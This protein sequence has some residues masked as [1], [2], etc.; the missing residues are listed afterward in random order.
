T[1][2]FNIVDPVYK[3][4]IMDAWNRLGLDDVGKWDE[5]SVELLRTSII[6]DHGIMA[7][8]IVS[9]FYGTAKTGMFSKKEISGIIQELIDFIPEDALKSNKFQKINIRI[10]NI[11]NNILGQYD[12]GVLKISNNLITDR[13]KLKE[14]VYHELMHWLH[15]DTMNQRGENFKK[16]ISDIFSKR[17]AG[18]PIYYDSSGGYRRDDRWWDRY[19][20]RV[21]WFE[22]K[23]GIEPGSEVATMH[24]Q[25]MSD[26][27]YLVN[28]IIKDPERFPEDTIK[29]LKQILEFFE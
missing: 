13:K 1:P 19:A 25:L 16:T 23:A 12:K 4:D 18:Y 21:Y 3:R 9:E 14:T 11:G 5:K 29:T 17:T 15:D 22:K 24:F 26:P 8:E 2:E 7:D 20:G 28:S 6:K 10:G 27:D